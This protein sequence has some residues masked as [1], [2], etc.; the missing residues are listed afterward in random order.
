[1]AYTPVNYS[2]TDNTVATNLYVRVVETTHPSVSTTDYIQNRYWVPILVTPVEP[3]LT[4]HPITL[5]PEHYSRQFIE[6]QGGEMEWLFVGKHP[7]KLLQRHTAEHRNCNGIICSFTINCPMVWQIFTPSPTNY[8]W[9]TSGTGSWT[10]AAN[11]IPPR[12]TR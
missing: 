2:F 12:G 11:W 6:Y 4:V 3:I 7:V 8:V 1:M 10:N 9:N 5:S